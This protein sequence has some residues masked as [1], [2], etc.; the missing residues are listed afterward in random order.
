MLTLRHFHDIIKYNSTVLVFVSERLVLWVEECGRNDNLNQ[1]G[2][3][4]KEKQESVIHFQ[5]V[6]RGDQFETGSGV[7]LQRN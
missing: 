5:I 6:V 7:S 1:L 2:K 3:P 4:C